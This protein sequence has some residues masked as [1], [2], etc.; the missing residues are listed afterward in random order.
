VTD[1][2]KLRNGRRSLGLD[3]GCTQSDT[4]DPT[5]AGVDN[6]KAL[7][8]YRIPTDVILQQAFGPRSR[9]FC[10]VS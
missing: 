4:G 6:Q 7:L 5:V 8:E 2:H 1:T 9:R 10:T 3:L